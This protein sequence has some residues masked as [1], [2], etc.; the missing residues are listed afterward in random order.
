MLPIAQRPISAEAGLHP[1]GAVDPVRALDPDA[2][3]G[4]MLSQPVLALSTPIHTIVLA[5]MGIWSGR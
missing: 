2:G 5:T 3:R 4:A 1:D